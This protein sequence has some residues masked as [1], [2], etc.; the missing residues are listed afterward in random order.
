MKKRMLAMLL[1]VAM[2]VTA[3]P[4]MVLPAF[5]A[6]DEANTYTEADYNALYASGIVL[7]FDTMVLNE[8]WGEAIDARAKFPVSPMDTEAFDTF[9]ER[10]DYETPYYLIQKITSAGKITYLL[11]SANNYHHFKDFASADAVAKATA[12]AN[13][14]DNGGGSYTAADGYTYK[15]LGPVRATLIYGYRTDDGKYHT[16]ADCITSLTNQTVSLAYENK[17]AAVE[18]VKALT[19]AT[20]PNEDGAYYQASTGR[21][22]FVVGMD[23]SEAYKAA[24][25]QYFKEVNTWIEKYNWTYTKK[26]DATIAS[27]TNASSHVNPCNRRRDSMMV[28]AAVEMPV[29][30]LGYLTRALAFCTDQ[31]LQIAGGVT[32]MATAPS[33]GTMEI[34]TRLG[35]RSGS[36]FIIFHNLRPSF[37]DSG[38][39]N[40]ITGISAFTAAGTVTKGTANR[41]IVS[42]FRL[43]VNNTATTTDDTLLLKQ[44]NTVLYSATGEYKGDDNT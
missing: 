6:E 7:G 10:Y 33:G 14:T 42:T 8:H 36:S 35:E 4:L 22:F 30:G 44:D 29:A 39:G 23:Q 27:G 38:K 28:N 26:G 9:E 11:G 15:V 25:V 13:A 16:F 3:L 40:D 21:Y 17:E 31:G 5:A 41:D 1:L 20:E 37:S 19:G 34:I 2:I 24:G 32:K 43:T 18:G 12:G